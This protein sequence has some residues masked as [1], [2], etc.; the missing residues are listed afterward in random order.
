MRAAFAAAWVIVAADGGVL[1]A[2]PAMFGVAGLVLDAIAGAV[3]VGMGAL[4]RRPR[5]AR[6]QSPGSETAPARGIISP[7]EPF[8][9]SLGAILKPLSETET[10]KWMFPW[11][12]G[13]P[14][15]RRLMR[16][17]RA[18]AA[19]RRSNANAAMRGAVSTVVR[20]NKQCRV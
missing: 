10:R 2:E 19:A 8:P 5:L 14:T 20:N 4:A 18:A 16:D 9:G 13:I 15:V 7:S 3:L 6:P 11:G 12:V 1:A 17:A